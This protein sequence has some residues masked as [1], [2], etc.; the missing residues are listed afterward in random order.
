MPDHALAAPLRFDLDAA[1]YSVDRLAELLG[2][3]PLAA[4]AR[5]QVV[6]AVRAAR[7]AGADPAALL[8]R[9]F[10][11]G[12]ALSPAEADAAL[13]RVGVDRGQ[14]AGLLHAGA[15]GV[16]GALDLRPID[17]AAGEFHLAAD[18]GE[19]TT[20]Q[21]VEAGH[22][23]GLG[24]AS[25][26]LA[27]LTVRR[28]VGRALDLGTGCGIQALN[29]APFADRVVATDVS[30]RALQFARFNAAL[31]GVELDLREGSM[32]EPVAGERFD[33]VVSNP[34]FV[35][36][37]RGAGLTEYTY[38]DG[39]RRGDDLVRELVTGVADVLAP[40]G[41]AQLL[42]N[43]EVHTGEEPFDRIQQWLADS[44]LDGW[45]VQRES[46]DP[47]EYA[48]TWLRDGGLTPDRDRA[49]WERGYAAWLADFEA[50]GVAAVGFG[51][52]T[53][54]RPHEPGE[55]AWHRVEEIT[56]TLPGASTG[57][58]WPAIA[59][60]LAAK[61]RLAA[62]PDA[63]LA[64]Q[65]LTVAADVTEERHYRPGSADPQV[66]VLRQGGGFGRTVRADTALA[67]MVGTSDGDL[68]VA[69]I[70]AGVAALTGTDRDAVLDS[71]LPDV[72]G[73]LTDGLLSLPGV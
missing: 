50:R 2:P 20:G 61:D 6:P 53:L 22:V 47:A 12:D 32:L 40:G 10:I 71:V 29:V 54:H 42:G 68:T 65:A 37:P 55:R 73:L 35:I 31:G 8:A 27:E 15:G 11:L 13:P 3:V 49:A 72:R 66:I 43:W 60:T 28:P 18:L 30:A 39:G 19:S 69:Q 51:Y 67:A 7:A 41:I 33:L 25:R 14:R 17:T 1:D 4:L 24:G 38:R 45:V 21:A 52:L 5:G 26:T 58:L 9:L 62:M 56:G 16:R 34:P 64:H 46:A 48:E 63:D 23:L 59:A 36:T 44:G 70:A 57:G